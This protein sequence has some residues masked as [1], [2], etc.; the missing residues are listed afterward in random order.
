[1]FQV[2]VQFLNEEKFKFELEEDS[3]I[4]TL[5]ISGSSGTWMGLAK[6]DEDNEQMVFY[7]IIPSRVAPEIR[8]IVME[9][10]TRANYNLIMG[11]FEMDLE[12]GEIRFKTSI[13]FSGEKL[14]KRLVKNI[15]FYNLI[16]MDRFLDGLMQVMF[17][18]I[19]AKTAFTGALA[20]LKNSKE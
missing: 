13:D 9:Y 3:K 11:N 5:F 8:P 10:I 20:Q 14:T 15:I 18:G 19:D 1:M 6:V 16:A 17:N 4:A 12:D 2:L 7:S